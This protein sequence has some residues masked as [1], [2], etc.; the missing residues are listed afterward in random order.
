MT[1]FGVLQ[2]LSQHDQPLKALW[3]EGYLA[4]N[5]PKI[6]IYTLLLSSWVPFLQRNPSNSSTVQSYLV[7]TRLWKWNTVFW[8]DVESCSC[9][10]K[11][12]K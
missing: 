7:A 8:K 1:C 10:T 3:N 12:F 11:G 2:L 9:I 4:D 6:Q 5:D